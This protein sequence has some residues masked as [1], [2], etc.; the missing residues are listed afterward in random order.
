MSKKSLDIDVSPLI[1]KWA[2]ES[3]GWSVKD[4]AKKIAVSAKTIEKWETGK[5]RL[6]LSI[7][8]K[9]AVS[10]KRPLAAFFLPTPPAE[11]PLPTDF[12][13]LPGQQRI[14]SK[15][16]RL[17]IR[18]ARRV[19]SLA[20]QLMRALGSDLDPQIPK[21][22]TSDDPQKIANE[23]R[24]RS[25][26][27]IAAQLEWKN[28]YQAFEVWRNQVE[29]LHILVLQNPMP[30]EDAR[31]FSL[32]D[33]TPPAI[34]L[35]SSDG[36]HAR[37][38]T[39]FHEFAH[40]LL[41]RPGICIPGDA[42][43]QTKDGGGIERWCNQFAGSFLIPDDLLNSETDFKSIARSAVLPS[44]LVS[45]LSQHLKVSRQ[46]VLVRMLTARLI[47]QAQYQEQISKMESENRQRRQTQTFSLPPAR[48][49]LQQKGRLFVSLVLESKDREL[50]TDSE[51]A[52]YLSLRLDQIDKVQSLQET[53]A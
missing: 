36:I 12:R 4:T 3:A 19:Q 8:E 28:P 21:A 34:M 22:S 51:A 7:L 35:S 26:V 14:L 49:C 42:L 6:S 18:R 24:K 44:Q 47:S 29:N 27:Q 20:G 40:L 17:A 9:L 11:P 45:K 41:Q 10:F 5:K 37:I 30:V 23:E 53:R 2:R 13:I 32:G 52:D 15:T 39:L 38:F 1:L 48:R 33:T 16:T 46:T 43:I 31:G 50:I 25:R